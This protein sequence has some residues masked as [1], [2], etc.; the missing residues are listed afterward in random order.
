MQYCGVAGLSSF[1]PI[2]TEEWSVKE[3]YLLKT[4]DLSGVTEPGCLSEY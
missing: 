3:K 4:E 1:L 2:F